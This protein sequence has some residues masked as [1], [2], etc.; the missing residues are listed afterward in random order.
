MP[1]RFRESRLPSLRLPSAPLDAALVLLLV[2]VGVFVAVQVWLLDAPPSVTTNV[3]SG[4]VAGAI[5]STLVFL[6]RATSTAELK[7]LVRRNGVFAGLRS[8]IGGFVSGS[9][10]VLAGIAL[11]T[12]GQSTSAAAAAVFGGAFGFALAG[13]T[14]ELFGGAVLATDEAAPGGAEG[15]LLAVGLRALDQKV[16]TAWIANYSGSVLVQIKRQTGINL[17]GRLS[18][19]FVPDDLRRALSNEVDSVARIVVSGGEDRDVVE[20][21][22]SVVT[23]SIE[24]YPRRV[25]VAAPAHK[26]SEPVEISLL[27]SADDQSRSLPGS[28]LLDISQAGRTVQIVEIGLGAIEGPQVGP[29]S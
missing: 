9:F 18:I 6:V 3:I 28:V 16:R 13:W 1:M 15:D 29:L 24:A 21:V 25:T 17:V 19:A 23:Q 26:S 27:R 7:T 2:V 8:V 10:A 5:V 12:A 14:N 20:F 22:V 11:L 4:G